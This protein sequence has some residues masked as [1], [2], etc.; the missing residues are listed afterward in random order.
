MLRIVRSS[1]AALIAAAFII[2]LTG[3]AVAQQNS[4]VSSP[5]TAAD[6]QRLQDEVYLTERDVAQLRTRDA[7]RADPLQAELDDLRDEVVYL[8]VKLRKERTLARSEYSDVRQRIDGV[9]SRARA[10]HVMSMTRVIVRG[11]SIMNVMPWR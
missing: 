2:S 8:K 9:R 7:G 6:I 1:V 5:V 11:S 3:A 4:A 10:I